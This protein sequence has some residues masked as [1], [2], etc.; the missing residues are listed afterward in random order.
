MLRPYEDRDLAAVLDVWHRAS[1]VAHSFLPADFFS[2]ERRLI[3]EQWL[4]MSETTVF[5]SSGRVVGF[6]SMVGD[7]V[8]GLFVHPEYQRQ[9]IG[10]LL[11]DHAFTGRDTLELGVLEANTLGRAFYAAYGFVEIGRTIDD[12]TGHPE[13]RLHLSR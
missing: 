12:A 11:M 3:A 5:E 2:A 9:G 10:G 4:P 1:L 6:I 8:G 7:E 13:L